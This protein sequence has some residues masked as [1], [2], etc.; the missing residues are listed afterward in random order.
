MLIQPAPL[1][2]RGVFKSLHSMAKQ[3]G[4]GAT[5]RRKQTILHLLRSCRCVTF[6]AYILA[7]KQKLGSSATEKCGYCHQQ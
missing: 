5:A 6:V 4:S 7:V 2:V 3:K 1:T